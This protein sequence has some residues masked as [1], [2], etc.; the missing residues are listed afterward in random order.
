[1]GKKPLEENHNEVGEEI[2]NNLVNNV[3]PKLEEWGE[4]SR[5]NNQ[6]LRPRYVSV[7]RITNFPFGITPRKTT[8]Y[9]EIGLTPISQTGYILNIDGAR[10]REEIFEH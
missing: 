5:R 7:G 10:N 1:L 8:S 3:I 6:F 4:S 9:E 2:E